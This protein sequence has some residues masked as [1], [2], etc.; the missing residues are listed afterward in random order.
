M[1][2]TKALQSLVVVLAIHGTALAQKQANVWY[3]GTKAGIDFSVDPPVALTDGVINTSEGCSTISDSAGKLLFYTDGTTVWNK[4]HA[5][6]KNGSGLKGHPSSTHSSVVVQQPNSMLYYIFTTSV[7]GAAG[8]FCYSIVDLNGDNKLGEITVKN[9]KLFDGSTEKIASV[10]HKNN[11][12]IWV[13]STKFNTDF[14]Y[15]YKVTEEGLSAT[16]TIYNMQAGISSPGIGQIKFS[17]DG[18]LMAFADYQRVVYLFDFDNGTGA[19]SNKR[20]ITGLDFPP[21]GL[22]I[23]P[24]AKYLYISNWG[25]RLYQC[26]VSTSDYNYATNCTRLGSIPYQT[27]AQIQ[28]APD[29]KIYVATNNTNSLGVIEAPDSPG[30]SCSFLNSSINLQS[31]ICNVGLPTYI[32][33]YFFN[34]PKITVDNFCFGDS[35]QIEVIFNSSPDSS[36]IAFGDGTVS[37]KYADTAYNLKHVY[38]DTGTYEITLHFYYKWKHDSITK[39]IVLQEQRINFLGNDTAICAGDSLWLNAYYPGATYLWGNGSTDSALRAASANTYQVAVSVGGCISY[40]TMEITAIPYPVTHL[41]SDT[42]F[43]Y[44]DSLLLNVF[45]NGCIYAWST[46]QND[47]AIYISQTGMYSVIKSYMGCETFDTVNLVVYPVPKIQIG[48]D[49]FICAGTSITLSATH[50]ATQLLWSNGATDNA[51]AINQPGL[52]W[53][54]ATLPPCSTTDTMSLEIYPR[55]MVYLGPDTVLCFGQTLLLNAEDSNCT[56]RWNTGS[57]QPVITATSMGKY[58]VDVERN[59]CVTHEEIQIDYLYPPVLPE[60][61]DTIL[62]EGQILRLSVPVNPDQ[63]LW[64][65]AS[66]A[67]SIEITKEGIYGVT[68]S[69]RCGSSYRETDVNLYNCNCYVYVPNV[70]TPGL[71]HINDVFTPVFNCKLTSY[72]LQIL[73]RWGQVIFQTHN[74]IEKWDGTYNGQPCISDVYV[75]QYDA[76]SVNEVGQLHLMYDS[77][78]VTLLR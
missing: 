46:G 21:Y 38:T 8:S 55:P 71:D 53:C 32:Q 3:F 18:S 22:E 41:P 64:S 51:I 23:S 76:V 54:K 14:L 45:D 7:W 16:T 29:G 63:V 2:W 59:T 37:G 57:D 77:G 49:T 30:L 40:D 15:L 36:R 61:P 72:H 58:W 27:Y 70:F 9:V 78:K 1:L 19:F 50:D 12:D 35:T 65:T 5:V 10:L 24:S 66:T 67:R 33:S 47:G 42:G 17:S 25:N 74:P 56:Y 11:K 39:K 73:N 52:H 44:G 20:R 62:C 34:K 75:W 69:N 60:L 6:M 31:G 13:I 43:C 68:V 4:L 26:P 28:A 48:S